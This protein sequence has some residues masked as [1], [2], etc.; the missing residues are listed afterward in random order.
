MYAFCSEPVLTASTD[1]YVPYN[2]LRFHVNARP[3]DTFNFL[4]G[5]GEFRLTGVPNNLRSLNFTTETIDNVLYVS[6]PSLIRAAYQVDWLPD[7]PVSD[8]FR[9]IIYH[10]MR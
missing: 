7:S 8:R 10:L 6:I 3:R 2:V 9:R 5:E 4:G 1:F